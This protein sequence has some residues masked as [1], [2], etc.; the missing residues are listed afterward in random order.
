MKTENMRQEHGDK[1]VT[2]FD[3]NTE[4]VAYQS[5]AKVIEDVCQVHEALTIR[6][7]LTFKHRQLD[8]I[9]PQLVAAGYKV[10]IIDD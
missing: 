5:S 6:G 10:A 4:C 3:N 2:I 7:A 1:T 8:T 9:Q